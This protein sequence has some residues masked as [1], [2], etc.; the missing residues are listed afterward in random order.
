VKVRMLTEPAERAY[1]IKN[2]WQCAA[3]RVLNIGD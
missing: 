3:D 1:D 2:V